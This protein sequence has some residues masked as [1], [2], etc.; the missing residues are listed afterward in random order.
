MN[1]RPPH[2][3]PLLGNGIRVLVGSGGRS[4]DRPQSYIGERDMNDTTFTILLVA[5]LI[6]TAALSAWCFST[7]RIV[8]GAINAALVGVNLITLSKL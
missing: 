6:G 5:V 8:L 2:P 7:D 3:L 4:T 1:A